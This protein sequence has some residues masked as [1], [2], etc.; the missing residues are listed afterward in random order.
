MA[1][2]YQALHGV[3]VVFHERRICLDAFADGRLMRSAPTFSFTSAT[4]TLESLY[5]H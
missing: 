5:I 1:V 3:R 4:L 2:Q